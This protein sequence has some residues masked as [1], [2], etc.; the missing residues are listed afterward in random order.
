MIKLAAYRH[1]EKKS[2]LVV[3]IK[4]D[5]RLLASWG[6][7]GAAPEINTCPIHWSDFVFYLSSV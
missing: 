2:F 1:E 7:R 3:C 4:G 6:I 5:R